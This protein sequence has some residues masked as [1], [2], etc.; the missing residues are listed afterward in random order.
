MFEVVSA[1]LLFCS[2]VADISSNVEDISSV[3]EACSL[4]QSDI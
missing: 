1:L 4:A 3:V 2:L